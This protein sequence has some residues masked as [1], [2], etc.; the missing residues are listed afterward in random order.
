VLSLSPALRLR[1]ESEPNTGKIIPVTAAD[2]TRTI[3]N[4]CTKETKW[5]FHAVI[6]FAKDDIEAASF[7]KTIK[8][9]VADKRYENIVFID[10]LSTPLGIEAF[11]QYVD[12]SA[13]AMYYNGNNNSASR[14]NSDK[15]RHVLDQDWKNRIYNGQFIVYTYANQEGEK[16]GNGEDVASVL[17]TIVT[18]RFPLAFDFIKGLS[19]TQLKLTNGKASAKSGIIQSTSGVVAGIEKHVL[20]TVWKVDKYWEAPSTATLPISKIKVE[21]DKLVKGAF[22]RDGQIS[23]GEIYDFLEEKY[24]FAPCNLSAFLAGFLLKEYGGEPFR[25]SDSSGGHES[26]TEDKLA[27]MLGN[28]IGKTP[29][30]TYIVKMTAEEMA[31]YKLTEKAWDIAP[32]SCSSA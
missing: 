30:P 5:N 17:Q 19:E 1:F 18:A 31:F 13:M 11:E 25:Y 12:Y 28:Y 9:A 32:N 26:M 29:K 7:R 14:E 8:A 23:I 15:A 16:L 10:A 6:A 27:E 24:G 21:V 3:N 20:P 4:L 2:F 22:N